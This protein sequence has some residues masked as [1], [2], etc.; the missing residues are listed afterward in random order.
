MTGFGLLKVPK[1]PELKG[2][3]ITNFTATDIDVQAIQ[4]KDKNRE[5]QRQK[6]LS[7]GLGSEPHAKKRKFCKQSDAW[8]KK[9]ER[10]IKQE[11][12]KARREHQKL[13]RKQKHTFDQDELDDLAKEANLI[14]KLKRGKIT[15]VEFEE[16]TGGNE[17]CS[18]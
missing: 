10:K 11:K 6:R 15:K 17:E 5:K 9:K 13:Q 3:E 16:R 8:S 1:M 12:R 14:K 2:K 18:E 7:D 4:Y